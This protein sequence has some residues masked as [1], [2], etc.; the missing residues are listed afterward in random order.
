M[1]WDP[2]AYLKRQHTK[3]LLSLRNACHMF[4]GSYGVIDSNHGYVTLQQVLDELN[5]REHIPNKKE[6]KLLRRLMSQ[7]R[8]SAEQVK[9]VPKFAT[10]LAQVQDRRVVSAYTYNLYKHAAPN[11]WV[12]KKMIVL[13]NGPLGSV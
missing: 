11:C 5:T 6:S 10:M 13:P 7:N 2:I 4:H 8:M 12:T 3:Q 9:A 1:D